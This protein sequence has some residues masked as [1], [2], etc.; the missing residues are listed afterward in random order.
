MLRLL[1]IQ[2]SRLLPGK[3]DQPQIVARFSRLAIL[4]RE[5]GEIHIRVSFAD[6]LRPYLG[7]IAVAET[8]PDHYSFG[9]G[10]LLL[11]DLW[12]ILEWKE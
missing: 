11:K 8:G 9:C 2:A 3:N 7:P 10:C 12:Q 4:A 6:L 5:L 1:E